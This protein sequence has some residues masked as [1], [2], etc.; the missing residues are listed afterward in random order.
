MLG[1]QKAPRDHVIEQVEKRV[2]KTVDV[3]YRTGLAVKPELAPG[4]DLDDLLQGADAAGQG[5]ETVR[6]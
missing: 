3:E 5:D 2:E 6:E 1:A 4:E